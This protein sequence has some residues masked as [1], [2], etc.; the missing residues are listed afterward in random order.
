VATYNHGKYIEQCLNSILEQQCGFDFELLIGEDESSDDT[1]AICQ[2][3]ATLHPD[4]IKLFLHSRDNVIT[5]NGRPT[6]RF[7]FL[8]NLSQCQG[9]YIALCEGD[10]YW[11]DPYKLQKQVDL[12]EKRKDCALVFSNGRVEYDA[13]NLKSHP[14]Y[15]AETLHPSE[16]RAFQ[17]PEPI[18]GIK[19]LAQG[20][21]IH[22]P[23]VLFRNWIREE[24][25][26]PYLTRT[27]IG[28]WPLHMYT[29][30]KGDIAYIDEELF[31]YRVH[32]GGVY[33]KKS[34]QDKQEMAL[35]QFEPMIGALPLEEEALTVF[36]SYIK[37]QVLNYLYD[38]PDEAAMEFLEPL[39]KSLDARYPGCVKR[40]MSE[41][42]ARMAKRP[43][44]QAPRPSL[45]QRIK[46]RLTGKHR[47]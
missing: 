17:V 20:N 29:A 42:Q 33:S 5:I 31:V 39:F 4:R 38:R 30:T 2:R 47:P 45:Y 28:D 6:G 8:Y 34:A 44:T 16:Y 36:L 43:L 22:T 35:G 46:R 41:H 12:L 37:K 26:P 23:G 9:K 25:I 14:V 24:G 18:T 13:S 40:I 1:R 19:D 3:I 10:D 21:Y 11:T 7:N 15:R 27:S 32:G